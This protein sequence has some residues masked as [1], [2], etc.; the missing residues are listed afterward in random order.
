MVEEGLDG[1]PF[2]LVT[3]APSNGTAP[4]SEWDEFYNNVDAAKME[5]AIRSTEHYAFC[6]VPL[7][8]TAYDIP[9][10]SQPMVDQVFGTL[11]G[12]KVEKAMNE[13]VSSLLEL[14]FNN[15]TKPLKQV[16]SNPD[17]DIL[18]SDLSN[19]K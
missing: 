19:C 13:I 7:L 18:L 2:V 10:E 5:L 1:K 9:P 8:L 6:D 12:R 14:V 15:N 3:R 4:I 17:I 11:D 16:D